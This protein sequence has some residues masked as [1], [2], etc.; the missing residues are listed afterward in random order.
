MKTEMQTME[1]RERLDALVQKEI[2]KIE[3]KARR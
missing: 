2:D 3:E 1:F